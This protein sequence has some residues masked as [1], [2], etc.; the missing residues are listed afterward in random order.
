MKKLQYTPQAQR[1]KELHLFKECAADAG[2]NVEMMD[3]V[4]FFDMDTQ[5]AWRGWM[6]AKGWSVR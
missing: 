6:A 4:W 1:I 5:N 2:Y 3:S